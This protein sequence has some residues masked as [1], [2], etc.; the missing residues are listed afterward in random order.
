MNILS[1]GASASKHSINKQFAHFVADQ[2]GTDKTSKIDLIDFPL[3]VFT[4]DEE[5]ENGFP[6]N[7]HQFL[8]KIYAADLIV[9]SMAEHNG[10]YTTW[11]KNLFDWASRV[12]TKFFTDKKIL[13]LSTSP[14]PRG[15]IGSLTAAEDRFPRHGAQI[16]A[17]FSLPNFETNFDASI[18]IL[19]NDLKMELEKIISQV[20]AQEI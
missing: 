12:N 2:F 17:T 14:G 4:V 9:I 8:E 1:F 7:V 20:K 3:T 6:A 18:G 11:F 5:K 15:G 13:L 19:N 16:L 10:S